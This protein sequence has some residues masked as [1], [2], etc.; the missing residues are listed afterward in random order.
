MGEDVSGW[1][2]W[3]GAADITAATGKTLTLV[4]ADSLNKAV[5]SGSATVT[6]KG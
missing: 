1:D 2:S 5:A 4:E 6:A 3:D